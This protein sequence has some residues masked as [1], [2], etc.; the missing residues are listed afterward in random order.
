MA[1]TKTC[2]ECE[3]AVRGALEANDQFDSVHDT[4]YRVPW[5]WPSFL[6]C[7][8]LKIHFETMTDLP[9]V[10]VNAYIQD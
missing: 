2:T 5:F 1:A 8:Q 6:F 4:K 7:V 3:A 9:A 10:I